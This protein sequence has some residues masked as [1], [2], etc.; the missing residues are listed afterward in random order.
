M[1][2]PFKTPQK[3]PQTFTRQLFSEVKI[4]YEFVHT[5]EIVQIQQICHQFAKMLKSY[6]WP[7]D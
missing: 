6:K 4:S 7:W 5:N 2:P 1:Y 3:W